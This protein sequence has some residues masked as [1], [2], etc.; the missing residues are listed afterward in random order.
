M[1]KWFV[2]CPANHRRVISKDFTIF[3]NTC[4][5]YVHIFNDI[6]KILNTGM[7]G[8]SKDKSVIVFHIFNPI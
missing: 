4:Q 7:V 2:L 8:K 3:F 5:K 6:L 1:I